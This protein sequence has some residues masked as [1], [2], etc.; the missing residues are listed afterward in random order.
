MKKLIRLK[1]ELIYQVKRELGSFEGQSGPSKHMLI[2][3]IDIK[4]HTIS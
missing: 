3:C 1:G 4:C 2:K